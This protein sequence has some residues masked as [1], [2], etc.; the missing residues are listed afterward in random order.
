VELVGPVLKKAIANCKSRFY[1]EPV[2]IGAA[3]MAQ[4]G[5]L[6]VKKVL[7]EGKELNGTN[8]RD[9]ILEIVTF[10]PDIAKTTFN[11]SST[12]MRPIAIEQNGV[13]R[14]VR[15]NFTPEAKSLA[16]AYSGSGCGW[17]QSISRDS[18]LNLEP[19]QNVCHSLIGM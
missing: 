12:A 17:K 10:K 9:A 3:F 15:I 1:N 18:E 13:N 7:D 6:F 14:R 5:L 2:Q 16:A 11:D 19:F 4:V 8:L